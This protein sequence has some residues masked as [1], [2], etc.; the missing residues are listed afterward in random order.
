MFRNERKDLLTKK[1]QERK[2]AT[3]NRELACL[4]HMLSKAVEWG[5]MEMNPF[6]K[7]QDLF[8]MENNARLRFLNEDEITK[9]ID[10][11][12]PHL[13]PMVICAINTGMRKEELLSLR[14]EQI[15]DGF[16]YLTKTKSK[17][18]RQIPVNGDLQ[19]LFISIKTRHIKGYVFC[20]LDGSR[21]I[22]INGAFRSAVKKAKITDFHFHDLRHTF[23]S[24]MLLRGVAP[25]VISE[26]LGHASVAFT[27]DTYSH[28]IEGMQEEAM[29]L[30]DEVLPPGVNGA[31]NKVT[32]PN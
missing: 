22:D 10:V 19:E 31:R 1:K 30:L 20:K 25:K 18:A 12:R 17:K 11:C 28:I 2:D 16:I 9:L 26:A 4:R 5:M 7:I 3:V 14:W 15:R 24:L 23:A 27:M 32:S 8:F 13:R 29:A 21:F 6:D